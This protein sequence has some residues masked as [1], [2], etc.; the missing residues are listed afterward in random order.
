MYRRASALLLALVLLFAA[1]RAD[2]D[3]SSP[4]LLKRAHALEQLV[5]RVIRAA[6]PSV[7][8]ILVS[9]SDAYQRYGQGPAAD[10]SGKLGAFDVDALD[11]HL[12]TLTLGKEERER[13]RRRLDLADS[14]HVPEGTGSGVVISRE[15]LVLTNYHVVAGATRLFVRLADRAGCYA[16]I[17]AGDP[18][19]DLAVLRL[20]GGAGPYRSLNIAEPGKAQQGQFV[21]GLTHGLAG[22]ADRRPRASLGIISAIDR[23]AAVRHGDERGRALTSLVPLLQTDLRLPADSSGGALLNLQGELIGLMNSLVV[24]GGSESHSPCAVPLDAGLLRILGVLRQG[25]EVEYGFLGV[26]FEPNAGGK[27]GGV[28]LSHVTPGSPADRQ[29]LRARDVILAVNGTAVRGS[30][31]LYREL[32]SLLAGAEVTLTV[33]KTPARQTV[34]VEVTLAKYYVPGKKIAATTAPRPYFRGLRVDYTSLLVQQGPRDLAPSRI[35]LGVL[36]SEVQPDSP[37]ATAFLRPGEVIT[38]VNGR[39][40]ETP[41]AFYR[42]VAG[43]TRSVELTLAPSR[44]GQPTSKVTLN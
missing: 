37:A 41:A 7:A 18:R 1:G 10:S 24:V 29:G 2:A 36:V 42:E 8:C 44:A 30:D 12:R 6:E 40:V 21:V 3:E 15:G 4:A 34:R 13:I 14:R 5:Q 28:V 27:A 31:E 22:T 19:S 17:L 38:H 25:R 23:P 26:G 39:P 20:L 9:R 32:G 43:A 35:P 16:D 11:R 33:Q